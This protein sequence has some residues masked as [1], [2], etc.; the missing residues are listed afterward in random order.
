[1]K[2]SPSVCVALVASLTEEMAVRSIAY[3][4]LVEQQRV[5]ISAVIHGSCA[6]TKQISSA[7]L[8]QARPHD[9]N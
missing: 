8:A 1:M 6:M 4:T 2:F 9:D 3:A 5:T 7:L